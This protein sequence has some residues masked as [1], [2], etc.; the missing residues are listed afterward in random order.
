[1]P[2]IFEAIKNNQ[3]STEEKITELR[4]YKNAGKDINA[5][6]PDGL[7]GSILHSA[8]K[9]EDPNL[10]KAVIALGANVDISDNI[11]G[12]PTPL[13]VVLGSSARLTP[14]ELAI[15]TI[16]LENNASIYP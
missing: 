13:S 8:I 10:V 15:F 2:S 3:F 4:K 12:I 9:A 14:V 5:C 16:L 11:H 7:D 1:M 6:N